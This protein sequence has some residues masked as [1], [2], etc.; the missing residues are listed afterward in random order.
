MPVASFSFLS[1]PAAHQR[2]RMVARDLRG[3]GGRGGAGGE[4]GLR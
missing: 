2:G 4:R 1:P 3:D